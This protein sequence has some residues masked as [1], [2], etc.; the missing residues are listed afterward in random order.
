MPSLHAVAVRLATL[1]IPLSIALSAY[2]YLYPFAHQCGFAKPPAESQSWIDTCAFPDDVLGA[3]YKSKDV[4]PFR[5]LALGDPQLEG[6]TSLPAEVERK[7]KGFPHLRQLALDKRWDKIGH[8]LRTAVQDVQDELVRR[9]VY[10]RKKLDLIGN[11]YYLAHIYRTLHWATDPTH[12]TV[13]GDL[14]GSQWIDDEEFEERAGRFWDR[15]FKYAEPVPRDV[16]QNYTNEENKQPYVE[17]LG[18]GASWKRRILNVAGNHDIGYAG[19]IVRSRIDRFENAFGPVNGD[20]S[21]TLP[22]QHCNATLS[23]WKVPTLRLVVL[24]SMNLDSPVNDEGIQGESYKFINA[25]IGNSEPVGTLS[26]STIL[27]THIPLH[28]EAG[29]CVDAPFFS[30]FEQHQGGG[31]Q[32]QNMLSKDISLG[33]TLQGIYGM[34]PDAANAEAE[35]LGRDGIIL[36]GHDHEGCDVYHYVDHETRGWNASRYGSV[37][38]TKARQNESVPGLREVTVRSMMGEFGGNAALVSAWWDM[39]HGKWQ[40]DVRMCKLGVQHIWWA[41]HILDL[42]T[43]V[44]CTVAA[45]TGVL[46]GSWHAQKRTKDR[47]VKQKHK[48][49]KQAMPTAAPRSKQVPSP[50]KK[51][52]AFSRKMQ[53]SLEEG[54]VERDSDSDA[55]R[56][57]TPSSSRRKKKKAP[58]MANK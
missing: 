18:E 45:I 1:L 53:Q 4:A 21:F 24:N 14:L 44:V 7:F 31:V 57:S 35:G 26:T 16:L 38:A 51:E 2:L 56:Q 40:I 11:D 28:K 34:S 9:V 5:L 6:D 23:H 36:T 22:A 48:Q 52:S 30:Y 10:A 29:V 42:V 50:R 13:L 55:K 54:R 58:L 8:S 15:V 37:E 27:L 33:A 19:D 39:R 12:V 41:I 43:F 3:H 32:E 47:E 49:L 20:I 46:S 25:V 17:V